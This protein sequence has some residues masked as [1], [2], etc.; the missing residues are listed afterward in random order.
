MTPSEIVIGTYLYMAA[1]ELAQETLCI[2][3]RYTTTS[4][5][6]QQ[7]YAV[8]SRMLAVKRVT[9]DSQKLK[10]ISRLQ[11][12]SIDLNTNTT[13]TGTPQYYFN[14][15]DV[16]GLY[17][18]PDSSSKTIKIWSLDE[19][20]VPTSTST[21]EIPTQFHG[22]LVIGTAYYMAMK[23]LG[24][25]HMRMLEHQ[26]NS[27]GNP[28]NCIKK[29]LRSMRKRNQDQMQRVTLEEDQPGTFIGMV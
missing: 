8:P 4:V 17:P 3:N 10:P 13:V 15:D 20:D 1:L 22:Y 25:P 23:E 12:D 27:P 7:E 29:T 16:F 2:E 11:L 9:Y 5:A 14:F 26:W 28:N 24:H 18:T 21:L 6:S 19:P